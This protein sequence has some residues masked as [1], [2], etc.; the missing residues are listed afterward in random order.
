MNENLEKITLLHRFKVNIIIGILLV[1]ISDI[2]LH[3][4]V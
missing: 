2:L 4:K 3:Q 1:K